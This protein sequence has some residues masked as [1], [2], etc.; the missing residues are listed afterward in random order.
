MSWVSHISISICSK[1][2]YQKAFH[3]GTFG[4]NLWGGVQRGANDQIMS[5]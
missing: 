1:K 4:E 5:R 2:S 3:E